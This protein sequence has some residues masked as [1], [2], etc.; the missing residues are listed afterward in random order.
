MS[1][2]FFFPIITREHILIELLTSFI[3]L[4][5]ISLVLRLSFTYCSFEMFPDYNVES[6]GNARRY[7]EFLSSQ[8]GNLSVSKFHDKFL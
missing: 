5:Y 6:D 2:S 8:E 3:A 1:L 4:F 7:L